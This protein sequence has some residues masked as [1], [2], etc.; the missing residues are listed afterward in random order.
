[1]LPIL[2][3]AE[4]VEWDRQAAAA[5]IALATLMDAAGRATAAVIAD[6]QGPAMS[7]GVLVAAGPG[8]NGGDG[9]VLA[10]ALHRVGVAVWV[11]ASSGERSPLRRAAAELARSDGVREVTPDGP[12]PAV[13]LAVD[14]LL[15]TGASGAP[16]PGIAALLERL[17]DLSAPIVAIDGPTGVDLSTGTV[18]GAARADVTITFGGLRRGHLLARDECGDL[19]VIDIGHPAAPPL[20]SLVTDADAAAWLPRLHAS[21]HKGVRGRVVVVGGQPGMN[22]AVRIAARAAFA[23]GAGLVHAVAPAETVAAL[24]Q[25]EPD[26]QTL[27]H[28]LETP[29]SKELRQLLE[30]ADGVVIGPGLGRAAGRRAFVAAVLECA[31]AAVLDA[32]GL[33]AYQGAVD[34]LSRARGDPSRPLVLT[35]H[36]GEFRALFPGLAAEREIDPWGAA[37]AAAAQLGCT[38]LLKGVPTVVARPDAP[39]LTVAAGNPG[40]ATG[41]SGDLLSGL[42]AAALARGV[43][44]EIAAALGAQIL[45]R[46]ADLAARRV[47]AR[48]MRPTDVIAALPDLWR[49]WE[50]LRVAPPAARPPVLLSLAAP[51]TV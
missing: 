47:T 37:R 38:I 35:P 13:G 28:E 8:N 32:D 10:R 19:V 25:G 20:P 41:G 9:W 46:A 18:H 6:R 45:G 17:H 51:E 36:P 40:L 2:S 15:G 34:E 33:V 29:L 27:A 16:R 24:V 12:W 11:A 42:V 23:A 14:A 31:A 26:L 49:E 43:S 39:L 48:G 3:P 50:V 1:M 4:S 7:Q 44:A 5:G 21:D 30:R 22:G